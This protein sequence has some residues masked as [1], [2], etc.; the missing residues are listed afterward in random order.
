MEGYKGSIDALLPHNMRIHN[1]TYFKNAINHLINIIIDTR[2]ALIFKTNQ[3]VK[4][5][6]EYSYYQS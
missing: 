5:R 6:K 3:R 4:A 2:I 1:F